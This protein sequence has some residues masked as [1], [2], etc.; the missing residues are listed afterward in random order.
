VHVS[1]ADIA[2][3]VYGERNASHETGAA[4]CSDCISTCIALFYKFG[5]LSSKCPPTSIQS[6]NDHA[7]APCPIDRYGVIPRLLS[8]LPRTSNVLDL[9]I[10][11]EEVVM[12]A[13]QDGLCPPAKQV[14]VGG[15][16]LSQQQYGSLPEAV[17][18]GLCPP[19]KHIRLMASSLD[20]SWHCIQCAFTRGGGGA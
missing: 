15:L 14:S 1:L 6:S 5:L 11:L 20:C 4:P 7:I 18:D 17:Q 8:E 19:E 13:V 12:K 2:L 10:A 9:E 3:S 16:M